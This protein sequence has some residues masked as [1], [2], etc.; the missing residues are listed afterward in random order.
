[1]ASFISYVVVVIVVLFLLVAL[2]GVVKTIHG[3]FTRGL[4]SASFSPP[5]SLRFKKVEPTI[6]VGFSAE[7]FHK[8]REELRSL[9]FEPFY[10][11]VSETLMARGIANYSSFAEMSSGEIVAEISE[12]LYPMGGIYLQFHSY[13]VDGFVL[14]TTNH[15]DAKLMSSSQEKVIVVPTSLEVGEVFD[16]H[17]A[18]LTAL[19]SS[20]NVGSRLF[21]SADEYLGFCEDQFSRR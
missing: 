3:H 21:H 10:N 20:R 15:S 9:G 2:A 11:C 6:P 16:R 8:T 19:R 17:W 7:L 18:E 4:F 5:M 14:K 1:M 12:A 13:F